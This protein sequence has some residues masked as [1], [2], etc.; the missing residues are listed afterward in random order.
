[1]IVLTLQKR[2]KDGFSKHYFSLLIL[3]WIIFSVCSSNLLTLLSPNV[4]GYTL[5][6]ISNPSNIGPLLSSMAAILATILAIF[7]SSARGHSFPTLVCSLFYPISRLVFS[8][9]CVFKADCTTCNR[10]ECSGQR[11]RATT[12]GTKLR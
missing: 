7:F 6:I 2:V 10:I 12:K 9:G 1:V 11:A 5:K 3:S 4:E 8:G